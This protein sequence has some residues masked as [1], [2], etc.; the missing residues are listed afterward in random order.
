ML[1]DSDLW[2]VTCAECGEVFRDQI[3]R[4]QS[5]DS[6]TCPRCGQDMKF[7][8][9]MFRNTI[10][11]ARKNLDVIARNDVLTEKKP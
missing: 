10:E 5:T 7:R 8:R 2:P 11:N 4:L 6:V 1:N 9:D 3:G